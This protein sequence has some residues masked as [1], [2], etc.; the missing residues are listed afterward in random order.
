MSWLEIASMVL[1]AI[2]AP[3]VAAWADLKVTELKEKEASQ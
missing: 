2:L 3:L 1:V